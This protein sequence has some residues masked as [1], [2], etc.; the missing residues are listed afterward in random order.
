[1]LALVDFS[2]DFYTFLS[3]SS[4]LMWDSCYLTLNDKGSC[5]DQKNWMN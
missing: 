4:L 3:Y 2:C 5:I 1:M